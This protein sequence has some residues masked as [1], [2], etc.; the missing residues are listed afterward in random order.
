MFL[1]HFLEKNVLYY[2]LLIVSNT[3]F[4]NELQASLYDL[5]FT[6][7]LYSYD[8]AHLCALIDSCSSG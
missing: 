1:C 8:Q 5:L 7:F 6:Q 4:Q 3:S 2:S